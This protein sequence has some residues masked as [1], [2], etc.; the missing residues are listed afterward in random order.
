[1][2]HTDYLDSAN[3]PAAADKRKRKASHYDMLV[4]IITNKTGSSESVVSQASTKYD[5][6]SNIPK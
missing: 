2:L 1:M 5:V 3:V 4:S 6:V